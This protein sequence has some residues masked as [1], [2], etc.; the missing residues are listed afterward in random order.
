MNIKLLQWNIWES[1]NIDRIIYIIKDID[2]DILCIQEIR[3]TYRPNSQLDIVEQIE[4]TLGMFSHCEIAQTWNNQYGLYSQGNGI[5]S[6]YPILEK[7]SYFLQESNPKPI[8]ASDEG[9][10]Y[11]EAVINA[12]GKQL[13]IGTTH[14]SYTNRFVTTK[15]KK[16]EIENLLKIVRE[17]KENYIL[18]GDLNSRPYSWTI[19]QI[20]RYL[21]HCGPDLHE[22]TWTVIPFNY[23]G[24]IE[25]ELKWRLDYVFASKNMSV[26]SAKI[27]NTSLSDH[28]PILVEF[29]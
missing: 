14:L 26:S 24:F 16:L 6:K 10:I 21:K 23:K 19:K 17:K 27:I 18:A 29:S 7:T 12:N 15:K 1:N 22:N 28:L 13:T 11:V 25:S 8:N 9:R 20:S 4:N 2:P 3:D 5:F